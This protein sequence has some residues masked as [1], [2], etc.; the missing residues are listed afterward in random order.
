MSGRTER[1]NRNRMSQAKIDDILRDLKGEPPV[2]SIPAEPEDPVVYNAEASEEEEVKVNPRT[3]MH[4]RYEYDSLKP[5]ERLKEFGSYI[6]KCM[7]RY[8]QDQED[9]KACE[10]KIQDI[11]HFME[12]GDDQKYSAGSKLYKLLRDERRE[13]RRCKNEIELLYPV[14]QMF[15]GTK[16][17]EQLS[18][19]QGTCRIVKQ[20]INDRLYSARTDVLDD[21]L[22]GV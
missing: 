8:E 1:K 11:L 21:F 14:Y 5:E 13:R 19:T 2:I 12:M 7:S 4:N 10:Q 9:L 15:H 17:L 20:S 6:R 3:A 16:I 18:Q 22:G